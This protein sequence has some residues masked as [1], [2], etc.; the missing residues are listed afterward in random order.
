MDPIAYL[1]IREIITHITAIIVIGVVAIIAMTFG[2][3]FFYLVRSLFWKGN[4]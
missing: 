2:V 4:K 3:I 1:V